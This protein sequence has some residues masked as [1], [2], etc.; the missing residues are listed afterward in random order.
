MFSRKM[1][2]KKLNLFEIREKLDKMTERIIWLIKERLGSR[3]NRNLS[4]KDQILKI[5]NDVKILQLLKKRINLGKYVA[6]AKLKENPNLEKIKNEKELEKKLR[7]PKR[8]K[9]VLERAKK[10]AKKY[11]LDPKV[12]ENLFKWLIKETLKVEVKEI[13]KSSR[14]KT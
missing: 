5:K 2:R 11:K 6:K 1:K 3:L 13:K 12:I 10:L 8:E 14:I 9:E 7:V 4:V